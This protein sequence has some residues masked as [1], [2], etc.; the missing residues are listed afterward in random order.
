MDKF[1]NETLAKLENEIKEFEIE[2]DCSIERIEAVIQLIIKCL[3]DVKKYI[4]KE[5]LR[6]LMKKFA[7]SNI[8]SQLS[9]QSSSTI[10]PSIKS[11]REDRMEISVPRNILSKN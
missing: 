6:M 7:F 2:A 9:F 5:D 4:L 1:Y 3:F 10:M 8:R 11:K